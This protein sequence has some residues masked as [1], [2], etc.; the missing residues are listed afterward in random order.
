MPRDSYYKWRAARSLRAERQAWEHEIKEH[1]M[2]IHYA[3]P[4]FGYPRMMTALCEA[5][6]RVNHKRVCRLMKELSI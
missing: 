6:F 5:C 4:Y 3:H 2:A 1:M